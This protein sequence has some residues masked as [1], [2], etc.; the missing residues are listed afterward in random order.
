MQIKMIQHAVGQGGLFSGELKIL[1]QQLRWVY[2]CGSNQRDALTREIKTVAAADEIDLLFL[3]HLDSD[4]IGGVDQLLSHVNIR[5]VVLP[6]LEETT[7]LATVARD[8]T[9]GSLN[10]TFLD[11]ANDLAGWFGSRGVETITL[12]RGL[13]DED[14]DGGAPLLLELEPSGLE[15]ER[16]TVWTHTPRP[17]TEIPSN[18]NI[19]SASG[20]NVAKMQQV[21]HGATLQIVKRGLVQNWALIPYVQQPSKKKMQAFE[22]ALENEFG[23]PLDKKK[24]LAQAKKAK[25][26]DK[27]RDCYDALW[28]DHNLIS[29]TLYSGPLK[30]TDARVSSSF[31]PGP[32]GWQR[33]L[34]GWMLTGDAHLDGMRR[35]QRFLKYYQQ[36]TPLTNVLMLPH[37]GSIHNHSDLVLDAMP[38][39]KIG[40]AAVGPN[41]YGHPHSD[42][43][44]AVNGHGHAYFHRV[45]EKRRTRIV[46][47]QRC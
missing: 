19:I 45:S 40:Y 38:H 34:G 10:G 1:R 15:G 46:M 35:R 17:V 32:I 43:E 39:L 7:L 22:Q 33:K 20:E 29:M 47:E 4:H 18:P 12:V 9:R 11:A 8:A 30:R 28:L 25:V 44:D 27:L 5:E 14:D 3:S 16:D 26:R 13:D 36:V 31:F 2:D 21:D 6:Y 42:V 23:I 37:H 41:S 24:I